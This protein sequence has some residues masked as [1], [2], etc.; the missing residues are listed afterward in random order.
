MNRPPSKA[1]QPAPPSGATSRKSSNLRLQLLRVLI[2]LAVVSLSVF[3]FAIRAEAEKLAAYG[4]PGIFVLSI[5]ANATILLPAPGIAFVFAM[6]A[7]F[8]PLLVALAAG[9]GAAIGEMSGYAAGFGGQSVIEQTA[10]YN[11]IVPW[12]QRYGAVTTFILAALPNPFFDLAGMAAGALKMRVWRFFFWC[13]MG[14]IV[15]MLAFAY[16]GAY[17]IDWLVKV[18]H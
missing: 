6:G 16:S 14:E 2:F 11:R 9:A 13:L 15:K 5:L 1:E 3:V 7:V 18:W 10:L 8:N 12:M 4:Y 17:S